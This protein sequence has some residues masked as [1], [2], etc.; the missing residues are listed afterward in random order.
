MAFGCFEFCLRIF[1]VP[2]DNILEYLFSRWINLK[3]FIG[4]GYFDIVLILILWVFLKS[5]IK[6]NIYLSITHDWLFQVKFN[7]AGFRSSFIIPF[8]QHVFPSKPCFVV[9][10]W[11]ESLAKVEDWGHQ[12]TSIRRIKYCN[13]SSRTISRG[14]FKASPFGTVW[15]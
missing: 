7:N 3:T 15:S 12:I 4:I 11:I 2:C 1:Y 5:T 8:I 14:I 10:V 13:N 9:K 6:I